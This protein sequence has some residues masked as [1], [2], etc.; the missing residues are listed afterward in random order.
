[1]RSTGV[2]EK[3][4][5]E[6]IFNQF[7]AGGWFSGDIKKSVY[8]PEND[9]GEW[10]PK[11]LLIVNHENGLP[12]FYDFHHDWEKIEEAIGYA[13]GKSVFFEPINGAVTALWYA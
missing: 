1:M 13:L 8:I 5:Q 4:A 6:L 12:D 11:S 3:R 9:P 7:N 2:F 10:A